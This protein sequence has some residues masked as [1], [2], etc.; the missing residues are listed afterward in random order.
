M[1]VGLAVGLAAGGLLAAGMSVTGY[2]TVDEEEFEEFDVASMTDADVVTAMME[3]FRRFSPGG[4]AALIDERDAFIAH[5]LVA[6]RETGARVVA[7]VGAGHREGIERY[8]ADPASLPPFES[9]V[10]ET[11][12][13]RVPWAKLVGFGISAAFVGFFVLLAL[14]TVDDADLLRL[15]AAWFAVN[16][17]FAAGLAKLAGARWPSALVGGAVAWLT[18][19]N[20]L[21]APGWFA[22]YME[23]RHTPVNVSDVATLNEL[24]D[25]EER[26]ILDLL[27]AMFDVPLFRLIMVVAL[28]NLG[29]VVASLLFATYVLPLFAA[30][31]GGIDGITRLM[32]EG[33]ANGADA[34][35][36]LVT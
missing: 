7:V 31:Y 10:G 21:L 12:G 11:G 16:G 35:W 4:A 9:L 25:D 8:L 36:R 20:P 15:F 24:L 34:V 28:T 33:A 26:P 14:S 18:S 13:G 3:E 23:L 6:L 22:G 5:R 1:T 29:S 32:I 19:I 17:V 27:G 30:D 2:G